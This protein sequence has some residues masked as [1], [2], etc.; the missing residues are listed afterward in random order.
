MQID[1]ETADG[2]RLVLAVLFD[3]GQEDA[4]S[5]FLDSIGLPY[6][7]NQSAKSDIGFYALEN[8]HLDIEELASKVCSYFTYKA[9]PSESVSGQCKVTDNVIYVVLTQVKKMS[10]NQHA[11]IQ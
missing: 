2:Q 10:S 3:Q 1:H 4:H 5:S 6:I 8:V 9:C 7:H 11:L